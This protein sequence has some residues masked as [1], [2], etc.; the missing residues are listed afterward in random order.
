MGTKKLIESL[1]EFALDISEDYPLKRMYLFG[2]RARKRAKRDSDVDLLLVS[3][4]FK[5]KRKIKRAPP[6]YMKWNLS[7]PVDFVCV[8]PDEFKK[9]KTQ[10]GVVQN[11]VEEGIR[12]L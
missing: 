2:S 1:K 4:T 3:S 8:S 11:A 6:L 12:I 9:K 7:Y 5:G 10:I